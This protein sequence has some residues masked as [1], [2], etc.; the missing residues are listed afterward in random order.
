MPIQAPNF[1]S[2]EAIAGFASV[3]AIS[4]LRVGCRQGA[5]GYVLSMGTKI[6]DPER[7]PEQGP[8]RQGS[9]GYVLSMGTKIWDPEWTAEQGPERT[10]EQSPERTPEQGPAAFSFL[11]FRLV[12][13]PEM[14]RKLQSVQRIKM[15]FCAF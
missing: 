12:L 9:N 15:I 4:R 2:K 7:T 3:G 14:A 6:W 8:E 10:P 13:D 1:V 11:H 5:N